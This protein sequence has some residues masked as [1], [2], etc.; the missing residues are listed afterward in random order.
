MA[1]AAVIQRLKPSEIN[2]KARLDWLGYAS[3][4][5]FW[6]SRLVGLV[7]VTCKRIHFGVL[8][9]KCFGIFSA[10]DPS[11]PLLESAYWGVGG[12]PALADHWQR[13]SII[14][15]KAFVPPF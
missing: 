7:A 14:P 3:V 12:L 5:R 10:T 2:A 9:A 13:S 4:C 1:R 11:P 8:K 6:A 15:T